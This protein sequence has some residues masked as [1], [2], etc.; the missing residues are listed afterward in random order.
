MNKTYKL[1]LVLGL[2]GGMTSCTDKFDDEEGKNPTWLGTNIYDY[3]KGRGDCN[4]FIRLIED[5][6]MKNVMQLSGSNTVFF[7]NDDAFNRF[8][9][10][11]TMGITSYEKMPESMKKLFLRFGVI[12]NAQLIER[13]SRSDNG[14]VLMRRTTNMEVTDTIPMVAAA[15]LPDNTYFQKLREKG[16]DVRLLQDGTKWTL[17]QF[18]P[19]V[20][21]HKGINNEDLRFLMGNDQVSIDSTYLY[22]NRVVRQDLICKNGYLHELEN[23]LLP[24]DNMAGYIRKNQDLSTFNSLMNRFCCPTY[25]GKTTAGDS[26][27]ELR[28]F[29][30]GG[31][32]LKTDPDGN[33]APGTL[34]YDPGWNLYASASTS[35][36]QAGYEQTMGCMFVPTNEAMSNFFSPNGEGADFYN[37]FG[38][39]ENVPT[40]MV[41]DIINANMKNNF[42]TA[43]PSKFDK[44]EDE[45]GYSMDVKERDIKQTYIARNGLLYITNKVFAPQDYK[46]VMGPA[47]ID[48][49][50]KLFNLAISDTK[51]SYYAYLLRAPKNTYY[52]FVTPDAHAKDYVDPVTQ[53]YSSDALKAKLNF[54]V[55][56]GNN[57][58]ATPIQVETGDTI[59]NNRFPLG[60]TNVV[61]TGIKS[62]MNDILGTQTIV[63]SYDGDL[64]DRI[65]GGQEWFVSNS[66]AP[67]HIKSLAVGGKVAGAGNGKQLTIGK[68]FKKSN[69]R[70][71]EIDGIVQNT[72]Q[73]IYDVLKAHSEFDEFF[74][75]CQAIGVF[76][77]ASAD[78]N[79][80][81][82][83]RVT[84]LNQYHYT[85]YVPTNAAIRA[86]QSAGVIPTVDE[87]ENEGDAEVKA[88]M[89]EKLMRFV[90]YHFQDNSVFIHG[91]KESNKDYL[92]STLNNSTSKFY[93]ITVT[94]TGASISLKTAAGG[95]ANVVT[96][97]GLYNL[98][99]RDIIVNNKDRNAATEIASSS[100]AVIHQVDQVLNFETTA[101]VKLRKLKRK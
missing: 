49:N 2:L 6:G 95:T 30:T 28:Y 60:A 25:Y 32:A 33:T 45:N 53:G 93:P 91:A 22:G 34:L 61:S 20:M 74:N 88:E 48:V 68:T 94:N 80:A 15:T 82:D 36:T 90:R 10:T 17:V 101:Q 8:Y 79:A 71:F 67:V 99:A 31:R 14:E 57:I 73:S 51:Y 69:G 26:I 40:S 37:A 85:V 50:N 76:S 98:M 100:Y 65:A 38:S 62:R 1:L 58:V 43:L 75:I 12:N 13:L 42:L 29:N 56:S 78:G 92:S 54:Y 96:S 9:Q 27:M 3:L 23:V 66:Y 52:F 84:F 47:K 7:A 18:F 46:T 4:N 72:T 55:N 83:Y 41:A 81:L 70:T 63:A 5:E 86:A 89:T 11:N 21:S 77:T 87:W 97:G 64:E 39:W 59:V 16:K 19:Y 35:G 24:P 44:I